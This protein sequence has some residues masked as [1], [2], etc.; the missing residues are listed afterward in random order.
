[1]L[2]LVI[3]QVIFRYFLQISV[4]WTERRALVLRL[5]NLFRQQHC[6]AGATPP[7]ADPLRGPVPPGGPA[8]LNA[9]RPR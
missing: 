7:Q 5:A 6:H 8:L 3:A 1:M 4:P 2:I 9:A